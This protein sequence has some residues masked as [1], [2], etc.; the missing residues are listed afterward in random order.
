MIQVGGAIGPR[1]TRAPSAEQSHE[2]LHVNA[3]PICRLFA[4]V[5]E[6]LASGRLAET[7]VPPWG[8]EVFTIWTRLET[9]EFGAT[10]DVALVNH[11]PVTLV[12]ERE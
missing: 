5:A 12:L 4:V 3:T 2:R 6:L 7:T 8:W 10:M 1:C 11:G 9:G